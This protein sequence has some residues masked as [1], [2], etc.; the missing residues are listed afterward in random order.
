MKNMYHVSWGSNNGATWDRPVRSDEHRLDRWLEGS[1]V[2]SAKWG[3]RKNTEGHYESCAVGHHTE[4]CCEFPEVSEIE[5]KQ[6]KTPQ[7]N[8]KDLGTSHCRSHYPLDSFSLSS[9][10]YIFLML[11]GEPEYSQSERSSEEGDKQRQLHDSSISSQPGGETV[12]VRKILWLLW[13][14]WIGCFI[15]LK[16]NEMPYIIHKK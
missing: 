4:L 13:Q 6:N 16:K 5:R 12:K 7:S 1:I 9:G 8:Q 14:I 15:T 2:N 3:K 10:P 11:Y